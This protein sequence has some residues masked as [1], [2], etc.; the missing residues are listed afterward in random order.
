MPGLLD[1]IDEEVLRAAEEAGEAEGA[2]VSVAADRDLIADV[3]VDEADR[4]EERRDAAVPIG[5][6]GAEPRGL[7]EAMDGGLD[8]P[9]RLVPGAFGFCP[10]RLRKEGRVHVHEKTIVAVLFDGMEVGAGDRLRLGAVVLH[11][12]AILGAGHE[13]VVEAHGDPVGEAALDDG[14]H[15]LKRGHGRHG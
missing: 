5:I 7:V 8:D 15:A 3:L 9:P 12:D 10:H 2:L 11:G 1:E 14:H 4:I 13:E 6:G